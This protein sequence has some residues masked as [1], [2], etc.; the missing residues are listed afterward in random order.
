MET[1]RANGRFLFVLSSATAQRLQVKD[2][3][4][5]TLTLHAIAAS[6][7][8]TILLQSNESLQPRIA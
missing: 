2:D 6:R 5:M 3:N 1:C 4:A 8:V 7:L